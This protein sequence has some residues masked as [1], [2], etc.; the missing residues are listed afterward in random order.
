MFGGRIMDKYE[1]LKKEYEILLGM[2]NSS[3][4]END[5][6]SYVLSAVFRIWGRVGLYAPDYLEAVSG[7]FGIECSPAKILTAM[8]CCSEESRELK[9][10][11]FF[12]EL[13]D[14]DAENN[15][16]TSWE[17]TDE[18]AKLLVG[19][20]CINGDFTIEEADEV[21]VIIKQLR[22]ICFEKLGRLFENRYEWNGLVTPMKNDTYWGNT[23]TEKDEN[24]EEQETESDND[25]KDSDG[26]TED[27]GKIHLTIRISSD[28]LSEKLGTETGAGKPEIKKRDE[29][30]D[31]GSLDEL[32]DE[33]NSL[34]GLDNVKKDVHSLLNFLK[35]CK[36]R[37]QRGMT[38]PPVSYHLV[39]T[40]NPGT[41]KTTVA[42]LVASI[43][44]R[45]GLL[46][47]GQLVETDRSSLVAGYLGQTA[48]KVQKVINEAI[49][50]V[51]FIDEA[52]SLVND[53]QDSFGKEAIETLLKAMEDHRDELVVIVAG[54]ENLM[55][56]FIDSNPGLRSRFNKY[57]SS[58][59][60]DTEELAE[61]FERFCS[62]NGY[63]TEQDTKE[64][65]REKFGKIYSVREE[66]FGNARTV[67]NIFEKAIS[68]QADRLADYSEITDDNLMTISTQDI[69][70]AFSEE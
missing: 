48:I 62:Q 66:H 51:L 59:D 54:Y 44:Y 10:P 52:Y 5:L 9:V 63:E 56:D 22:D 69:E 14:C 64:L 57:F 43:Y 20:A 4:Y 8:K 27:D 16:D 6:K 35:I 17:F 46:S 50:G 37:E 36:L 31:C 12:S 55:K 18:L 7:T 19:F 28:E 47:Q 2:L 67:R 3:V 26:E 61:I 68:N 24:P 38:V 42:R 30:D 45:M 65:L 34:V 15:T 53:T 40:G 1:S 25:V 29:A 23:D 60:Y 49:G 32:L 11:Y 70:N 39:F 41:G 21:G 58:P 13:A 33:L